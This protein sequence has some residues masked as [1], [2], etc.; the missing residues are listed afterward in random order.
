MFGGAQMKRKMKLRKKI[1]LTFLILLLI[2]AGGAY[3][4]VAYYFSEHFYN[5][6]KINGMDCSYKTVPE[7]KAEIVDKINEYLLNV[8]ELN[9]KEEKITA[10]QINLQ[11]I[12]DNKVDQLMEDQRPLLWMLSFGNS[13]SFEMAANTSYDKGLIDD[14]LKGLECFDEELVIPPQDAYI[15]ENEVSF[16]IIP[17][18]V[19]NK[20][21]YEEV[22][23]LVNDAI[24]TG[25]TEVNLV[26]QGCY[27]KPETYQDNEALIVQ[28]DSLNSL[29]ATSITYDF[30]AERTE[31]IN[32]AIIKTW[33][34][35]DE[36]GNYAMHDDGTYAVNEELVRECIAGLAEKYD[37]YGKPR[38]FET[39]DGDSVTLTQG[40]YGWL[41][42]QEQMADDLFDGIINNRVETK[43]ASYSQTA[44]SHSN[45]DVGG[46]YV[47]ISI[48]EQR[49]WCY[50]DGTLE[51]DTPVVTGNTSKGW[52]TP[53]GGVWTIFW[54]VSPYTL[55]GEVQADGKREYEAPVT[56]WLPFNGGV[57]IH[58]LPG[59]DEF[60]GEIYK[61]NGSHGCVNTPFDKAAQIYSIVNVGTPV[62]VY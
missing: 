49:M 20:L 30:G 23:T 36:E 16:E 47:E 22:K 9:G 25:K 59:R 14:I 7:V 15:Q 55:K 17:E 44:K 5:G 60:G 57:G 6:S 19:G 4:Y 2:G 58:D 1:A 3:G 29:A 37:T 8:K 40:K 39:Y 27:E 18:V 26:D 21:K 56:Y 32:W 12:D 48:S 28:R 11:Y 61:N 34:P 52:D 10:A 51:V 38:D 46:T 53:R 31:V 41:V 50:K 42:A 45:S 13:N 62:V 54:K 43:D 24:D 33:V 35:K